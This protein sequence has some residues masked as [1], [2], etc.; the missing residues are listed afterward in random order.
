MNTP[1]TVDHI[2]TEMIAG[3]CK[4]MGHPIRIQIIQHLQ[5]VGKSP[6]GAIVERLPLAQSTVSQHLKILQ[7]TGLIKSQPK[8]T[9]MLYSV[10]QNGIDTFKRLVNT[11]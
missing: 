3:Y 5:S 9:K 1:N 7:D 6:C 2:D 10:N 4:A 8:G 11:V